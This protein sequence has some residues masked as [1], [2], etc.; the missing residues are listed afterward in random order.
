M[1]IAVT[2]RIGVNIRVL[3]LIVAVVPLLLY[4]AAIAVGSLLLAFGSVVFTDT[5]A[6]LSVRDVVEGATGTTRELWLV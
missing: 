3:L 2:P 6:V 4:P 1:T 5:S